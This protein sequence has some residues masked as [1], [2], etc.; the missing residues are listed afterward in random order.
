MKKLIGLLICIFF[1]SS[2]LFAEDL[3]KVDLKNMTQKIQIDPRIKTGMFPN[4]MT[5]YI[6][7]NAKPEK[8]AHFRLVVK[9][10]SIDEDAD[11]NGLA[12]F[13]EH[14]AFNGTKNFPKND[15]LDVLQ[16]YGIRFGADINASTG[17]DKTMYE[18]PIPIDNDKLLQDAFK[19]LEDWAHNVSYVDS[20]IESERGVIVAEWRQR[21]NAQQR[22]FLQHSPILFAGSKFAGKN[23]IGDTNTL[24]HFPYSAIRRYYHDWYRPDQMAIIAVGDFDVDKIEALI[25]QHFASIPKV[26]S[27]RKKEESKIPVEGGVTVSIAS[28]KELPYEVTSIYTKL[29]EYNKTDWASYRESLKRQLF[30]YMFGVRIAEISSAEN[31]PFMQGGGGESQFLGDIRVFN[32]VSVTKPG[33]FKTGFEGILTEA[34]RVKQHGFKADEFEEAKTEILAGYEKMYNERATRTHSSYVSEMTRNFTD[35]ESM[36]GTVLE[37]S[38]TM[39]ILKQITLEEVNDLAN[40]YLKKSNT[41]IQVS[42]PEKEGQVKPTEQEVL[43]LFNASFDK[44]VAPYEGVKITKPLFDKQVTPGKIV[45][46][47][48]LK[49]IDTKYLKLSNGVQVYLKPT[50]FKDE[51]VMF[52][53]HSPG[54]LSMLEDVD[55]ISGVYA[56]TAVTEAGLADHNI[57]VFRKLLTGKNVG[58]TPIIDEYSEGFQGSSTWK[59]IE[60]LFQLTHLYFKYPRTDKSTF[61]SYIQK[62][63]PALEN[64]GSSQDQVFRDSVTAILGGYN[65]R[66]MPMTAEKLDQA[67]FDAAMDIYKERFADASDFTFVFVGDFKYDEMKPFIEKY[68]GSLPALNRNE[69]PKDIGIR[70]PAKPVE[71]RFKKGKED[72]SHVRLS[73][74]GKMEWSEENN[75]L[76]E[77]LVDVLDIRLIKLIREEKSGVYSPGVWHQIRKFPEPEYVINVDF[78]TDPKRVDEL[79]GDTRD[80]MKELTDKEDT[81]TTE[82]ALKA[83]QNQFEKGIKENNFW[84]S[85]IADCIEKDEPFD[86][87]I[88]YEKLVKKT[89]P[90]DIKAA[91]KKY[92]KLDRMT[93]VVADPE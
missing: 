79:I 89:T 91:A 26:T 68:L 10:G 74:T 60:T 56:T 61:K 59:D 4:G 33:N 48:E 62:N 34:M 42:V 77:T 52:Y 45:E 93:K 16:K 78:V 73:I 27:P 75:H 11:Q 82:K 22:L 66:K 38:F 85:N 8:Q 81:E 80:L 25:K 63:R 2:G 31:P 72:R 87:I 43:A 84:M 7:K 37:Y 65:L 30:D 35:N 20:M 50:K 86:S 18:L 9:T 90:A 51:Q 71:S 57:K 40:L 53:A 32:L 24:W 39:D 54:G 70:Y 58:I 6:L 19:I 15:L 47:K 17:F 23:A 12:H 92:F 1:V 69:K 67:D 13:C 29:P 83:Q 21:N 64:R 28:D 14:M 49:N 3:P 36:P 88:N 76:L 41:I 5:Y 55:Y 44:K 46:E